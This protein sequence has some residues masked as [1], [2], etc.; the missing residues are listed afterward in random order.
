MVASLTNTIGLLDVVLKNSPKLHYLSLPSVL[1]GADNNLMKRFRALKL[2]FNLSY[3]DLSDSVIDDDFIESIYIS[4]PKIETIRV[5]NC[6]NLKVLSFGKLRL[7]QKAYVSRNPDMTVHLGKANNMEF[8][9]VDSLKVKRS[10]FDS[11]LIG[12]EHQ[13]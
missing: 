8:L 13:C 2:P 3:L 9:S 10:Y 6:P 11:K 1:S 4:S 12:V 5:E 7:L